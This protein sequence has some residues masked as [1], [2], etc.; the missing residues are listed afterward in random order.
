MNLIQSLSLAVVTALVGSA[1]ALGAALITAAT[2]PIDNPD[3]NDAFEGATII[4]NSVTWPATAVRE[5]AADLFGATTTWHTR[6]GMTHFS[7]NSHENVWAGGSGVQGPSNGLNLVPHFVQFHTAA[8]VT[9]AG[10]RMTSTANPLDPQGNQK[11]WHHSIVR[12]R[13]YGSS[14][15]GSTYSHLLSDVLILDPAELSK[16]GFNWNEPNYLTE[17]DST[18]IVITDYFD[19]PATYQFF[20]AEFHVTNRNPNDFFIGEIDALPVPEPTALAVLA[21]AGCGLVQ[22]RRRTGG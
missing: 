7:I 1:S 2:G 18:D 5:S 3:P 12:F 8:P 19:T 17:F 21:L 6:P 11:V 9:I 15:G 4:S 16:P 22:R 13:L 14:D 10:V 20:R